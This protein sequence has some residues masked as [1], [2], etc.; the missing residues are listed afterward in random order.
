MT[1][2]VFAEEL[3]SIL[4]SVDRAK[5]SSKNSATIGR[6]GE[7]PLIEFL[8]KYLPHTLK[9]VSGHFVSPDRK[10]SPQID[11]MIIDT[12]YP[13]LA[14]NSDNS[15]LVMGHSV[16]KIIELK[17]NL[18]SGDIKK[19][20]KNFQECMKLL[21]GIWSGDLISWK[22]PSF[23]IVAYRST[24]KNATIEQHYHKHCNPKLT[25]FNIF[26]FETKDHPETGRL[27]HF[28]PT[29]HWNENQTLAEENKDLMK[30][31]YKLTTFK[32]QF[33]VSDL[34]YAIIQMTYYTIASRKYELSEIASHFDDY[35]DWSV[36]YP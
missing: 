21:E 20:S 9:A 11:C 31:K 29:S 5:K 4:V 25:H 8:N 10:K 12:R 14:F 36:T 1:E 3:K 26:V 32:E 28:E 6:N 35:L 15:V 16:L 24:I 18:R 34:Y 33:P 22:K 2:S 7:I 30:N 23:D 19:S 13:L 27:F 17:T